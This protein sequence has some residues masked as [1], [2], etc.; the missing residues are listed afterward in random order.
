MFIIES[1]RN[2]SSLFR[3]SNQIQMSS[4]QSRRFDVPKRYLRHTEG[5]MNVFTQSRTKRAIAV[6]VFRLGHLIRWFAVSNYPGLAALFQGATLVSAKTQRVILKKPGNFHKA[7]QDF[8]GFNPY[9][10]QTFQGA[11]GTYGLSATIKGHSDV[12][13]ATESVRPELDIVVRSWS[14]YPPHSPT[15]EIFPKDV[16]QGRSFRLKVRYEEN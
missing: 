4:Q 15:L 1:M 13:A 12:H 5:D 7:M 8:D 9:N 14:K 3:E 16:R 6:A 2:N 10:I 11:D